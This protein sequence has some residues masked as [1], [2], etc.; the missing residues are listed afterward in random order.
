M[1]IYVSTM[2]SA[3][4]LIEMRDNMDPIVLRSLPEPENLKR[5]MKILASLNIILCQEEWLRY[6]SFVQEWK[7]NSSL[8]KI[9]NGAG[10]HLYILFAPEGTILKG[11]DHESPLSPH[12]QVEYGIWPGIYEGLPVSLSSLLADEALQ[13]EDVTFC[14]WREASDSNWQIGNVEVPD[15]EDDGSGFLLGTIFPTA[16][17]F[18]DFAQGYFEIKLPLDIVTEIY[19]GAAITS[20]MI[21]KINPNRDPDKVLQELV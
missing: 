3:K 16:E 10:D 18:V 11:F 12:A 2:H 20:E 14:I 17:R 21:L 15:G 13:S 19:E 6:H 1:V 4:H 5:L 7:E 9:D 8:A